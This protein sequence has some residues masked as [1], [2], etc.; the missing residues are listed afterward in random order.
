MQQQAVAQH[1][2]LHGGN[3]VA[4]TLRVTGYHVT[5]PITRN[6]MYMKASSLTAVLNAGRLSDY[7]HGARVL[8]VRCKSDER[9]EVHSL[10]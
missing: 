1:V 7:W 4:R 6:Y 10:P 8:P 9:G 5:H 2:T 3:S